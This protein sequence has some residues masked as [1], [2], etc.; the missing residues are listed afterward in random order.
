MNN[1]TILIKIK[2]RLNKLSSNDYS[3]IQCWQFVEA[4]NKGQSEWCRRNA[5]GENALREG[6][7]QSLSRI[8]DL[9]RLLVDTPQLTFVDKGLY[10]QSDVS[11]WPKDYLRYKGF[12]LTA[13]N[14]CCDVP[15]FMTVYLGDEAD[16]AIYLNDPNIRPDYN[17]GE[18]FVTMTGN[19]LNLYHNNQFTI[20]ES[21][22]TYYRQPRKIQITGCKDPYTGLVPTVD[23]ECEFN[24]D[25]V[26]ILA[27]E[28]AKILA[29]DMENFNQ[30][31]RLDGEVEKNN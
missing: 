31:Q 24:D 9:Q 3:N 27:D 13:L 11:Q 14:T 25:L 5:H 1:N 26:E 28:A 29:G 4:F 17:W 12:N 7:E 19:R 20:K 10:F 30:V 22:L 16:V 2:E 18:T 15:T 21:S 8:D 6:D 23:V